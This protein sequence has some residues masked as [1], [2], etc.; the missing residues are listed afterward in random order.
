MNFRGE[1]TDTFPGFEELAKYA[2][3]KENPIVCLYHFK[4]EAD[5][6]E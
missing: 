1:S 3:E 5:L 6:G 4:K 2:N